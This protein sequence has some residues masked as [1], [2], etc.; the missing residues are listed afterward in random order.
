MEQGTVKWFNDAKASALSASDWR[1][2]FRALLGHPQQRLPWDRDRLSYP[3]SCMSDCF[4]QR[5]QLKTAV[6]LHG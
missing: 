1:R 5:L 6:F 4:A 2:C 3:E